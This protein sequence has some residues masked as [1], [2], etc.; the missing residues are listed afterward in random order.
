MTTYHGSSWQPNSTGALA[1]LYD[2]TGNLNTN[3]GIQSWTRAGV[4]P[5]KLVMGLPLYGRTWKLVDPR[6]SGIG[7]PANGVGLG[8]K[9]EMTYAEVVKFNRDRN[10]RVVYDEATV[11]V[12]SVAGNDWV[13]YDDTRSVRRKIKYARGCGLGG[14]FFWEVSG[15]DNQWTISR[16][17][18]E[19]DR[20][21]SSILF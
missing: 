20:V 21:S 8:E 18:I 12:Y 6:S 14:Y 11:A 2:P 10:A 17:G 7:A 19:K 13:S 5:S 1:A 15:D 4:P 16:T 3:S 9:G